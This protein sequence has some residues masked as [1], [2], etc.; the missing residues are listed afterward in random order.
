MWW[1]IVG[2]ASLIVIV[3][4][5]VRRNRT[6]I[7]Y[8]RNLRY[9]VLKDNDQV[10]LV[11]SADKRI[12]RFD[13]HRELVGQQYSDDAIVTKMFARARRGGGWAD[14]TVRAGHLGLV[15]YP[16]FCT[17]GSTPGSVRCTG[18]ARKPAYT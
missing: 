10:T 16:L 17:P 1:G 5:L 3:Y 4:V 18:L 11:F 9:R 8:N 12:I 2:C 6:A 14:F 13:A 7:H 15:T